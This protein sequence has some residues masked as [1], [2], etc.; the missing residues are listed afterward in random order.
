MSTPLTKGKE[1]KNP[2]PYHPNIE[3]E[4]KG[5]ANWFCKQCGR[6]VML[7]LVFIA[8]AEEKT[9]ATQKERKV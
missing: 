1:V 4:R 5:R 9:K 3:L 7:E 8:Q 6:N 2:C